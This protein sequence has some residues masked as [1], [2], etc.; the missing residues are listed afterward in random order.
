MRTFSSRQWWII[1]PLYLL[2]GFVLGLANRP[3]SQPVQQ[4]G[5]RPGVAT[6]VNVNLLLPLLAIGLGAASPRLAT[7]W[8]GAVG[9]TAGFLIGLALLSPP[10]Q[11]WSLATLFGSVPPV[12]VIACLGYAILGTIA[13]RVTGSVRK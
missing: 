6:A 10:P 11:P 12:L 1:L 4:L 2:S 13:A 8:L 9:M 7:V 3:L 5:M